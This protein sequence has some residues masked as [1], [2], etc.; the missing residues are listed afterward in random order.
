MPV[1]NV[2]KRWTFLL[3]PDLKIRAIERDVDPIKDAGRMAELI[4]QFKGVKK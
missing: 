2:A 1:I 3:D 4:A